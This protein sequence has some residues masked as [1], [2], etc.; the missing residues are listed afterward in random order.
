MNDQKTPVKYQFISFLLELNMTFHFMY[1]PKNLKSQTF[2]CFRVCPEIF[3]INFNENI[4]LPLS[5]RTAGT[6]IIPTVRFVID[7]ID[8][9]EENR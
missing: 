5:P 7:P 1:L 9:W 2:C 8:P 4:V 3:A 6:A